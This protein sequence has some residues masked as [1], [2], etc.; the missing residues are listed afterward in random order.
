MI[1]FSGYKDF[2]NLILFF[3]CFFL[4]LVA[5]FSLA[6][7]FDSSVYAS[8]G[9][10]QKGYNIILTSYNSDT[11]VKNSLSELKD[12]H[13]NAVTF[14]FDYEVNDIHSSNVYRVTRTP[15]DVQVLYAITEAKKLNLNVGIKP[16][17]EIKEGGW[18]AGIDPN[19]KKTFFANYQNML[20]HYATISQ[21]NGVSYFYIG[22]ELIDLTKD[23]NK[24]YWD[25]LISAIRS[26]FKG[27]VYYSTNTSTGYERYDETDLPFMS[28][29]DALTLSMY[30]Q[31]A[32]NNYPT[33]SSIKDYWKDLDYNYIRPLYEQVQKPV[34]FSE[35][36]F[37]S[38]NGAAQDP[39]DFN[40][41][42]SVDYK[43]QKDLYTAFF[44]Y[45]ENIDYFEG[46]NFWHWKVN[47]DTSQKD[48]T[49]ED[50][51]AEAVVSA[52]FAKG[53]SSSSPTP[54]ITPSP[55]P[56][57]SPSPSTS[58]YETKLLNGTS[59]YIEGNPVN[60]ELSASSSKAVSNVI[61]DFE[62]Y[63]TN[64]S[65]VFQKYFSNQSLDTS[66]KQYNIIWTPAKPGV[67]KIKSGIFSSNWTNNY[68]WNGNIF[69]ADVVSKNTVPNNFSIAVNTSDQ[70]FNLSNKSLK[71][72]LVANADVS[73]VIVNFEIH[74]SN[75][76]KVFQKYYPAQELSKSSSK[77]YSFDWTP[78]KEGTYRAH[79]SVFSSDWSKKYV[80]KDTVA[81]YKVNALAVVD[82]SKATLVYLSDKTVSGEENLKAKLEGIDVKN[83]EMYWK[84]K[85]GNWVKM[86][87][88]SDYKEATIDF[89]NWTW[90]KDNKYELVFKAAD[91]KGNTLKELSVTVTV[92]N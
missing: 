3:T 85:G 11:D 86:Y 92:S 21:N 42:S 82:I 10:W 61:V 5:T 18:R 44:E 67:Y 60:F 45:W 87:N 38:V 41:N 73:D 19:D 24:P 15:S 63:D 43:E 16:H 48:Y 55:A 8:I 75:Y 74:D 77:S 58:K 49:P 84:V 20:L 12:I 69:T 76:K 27:K 71:F 68:F 14:T 65:K 46:V 40:L 83:Y 70:T 22:A 62:I 34:I 88:Q 90:H 66:A 89:S 54:N 50:K 78:P 56:T 2:Y 52:Y 36:G 30:P 17:L 51:P 79:V 80:W 31:L 29:L 81:T 32:N 53:D 9:D 33:V 39:W 4:L 59:S 1:I 35:I 13:A 25:T 91:T 26:K 57:I 6:L 64:N 37:R 47:A 23:A 28:S 72:D 7:C